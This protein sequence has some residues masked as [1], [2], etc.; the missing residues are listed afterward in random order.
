M[1]FLE[2]CQKVREKVG[3]SGVG[4]T[5]VTSQTGAHLRIVNCVIEAWREIQ[6][7]SDAW[8]FMVKDGTL[9]LGAGTQTYSLSTITGSLPL[10]GS[11]IAGT[12]KFSTGARLTYKTWEQWE[13]EDIDLGTE[14][15]QPNL[16]TE[17]SD[18]AIR[19][20]KIPDATYSLRF[21]YRR[22]PQVLAANNDEPVCPAA[23]HMAIV[24]RAAL[25]YAELD[26][27]PDLARLLLPEWQT[28]SAKLEHDQLP[29]LTHAPSRFRS[30][31]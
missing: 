16:W 7:S 3:V 20:Y 10:Y 5:A 2:I 28:W 25:M 21:R 13:A 23:F 19:F 22:S 17:D 1:T 24:Y 12:L 6:A 15:G 30:V 11:M 8:K 27:A 4:P 18:R 14:Q 29:T 26:E 9:S 31:R